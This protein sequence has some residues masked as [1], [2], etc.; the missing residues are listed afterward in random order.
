MHE[1]KIKN[2]TEADNNRNDL[3][4]AER[5]QRRC[6]KERQQSELAT[7]QHNEIQAWEGQK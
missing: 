5:Q 2:D 3:G 7:R 6:H 1:K 4:G